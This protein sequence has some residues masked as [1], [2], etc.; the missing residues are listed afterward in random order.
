VAEREDY[1]DDPRS[2]RRRD[3]DYEDRPRR[4]DDDDDDYDVRRRPA[5]LSGMDGFFTNTNIVVLV[6]FALCCNGIA[7]ILGIVGLITCTD[8][9]AKRNALTVTIIGGIIT[10]VGVAIHVAQLGMK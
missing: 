2:R 10:V 1:T 4:R 7:L 3:D 5:K 9:V 8:E 6:L